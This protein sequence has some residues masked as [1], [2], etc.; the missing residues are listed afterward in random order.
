MAH[1]K[2]LRGSHILVWEPPPLV[3]LAYCPRHDFPL[4]LTSRHSGLPVDEE[5]PKV[6]PLHTTNGRDLVDR[7]R[8]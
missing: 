4:A 8:L 2:C 1:G 6:G 7:V 5:R 3:R